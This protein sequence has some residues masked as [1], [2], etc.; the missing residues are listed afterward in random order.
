MR[1]VFLRSLLCLSAGVCGVLSAQDGPYPWRAAVAKSVITPKESVWMAG[2]A[3]RKGPSE[4]VLQDIYAKVL[5]LEDAQKGRMV[6]VTLDLVGIPKQLRVHVEKRAQKVN[7]LRPEQLLINASHTHSGPMIGV[8][9]PPKSGGKLAPTY[10][11]IPDD[12]KDFRVKQVLEYRAFLEKTIGDMI[13]KSLAELQACTLQWSHA[14]CGFS[15]NRRTPTKSGDWKNFPNPDGPVD[16]DVPVLQI[17]SR[18]DKQAPLAVLFGYACHATTLGL[19]EINGDWPGYA[20]TYFE[21]D[22]PGTVALFLNGASG[23]QNPYPR[24]TIPYVERH[25]RSMAT[26]IEAALETRQTAVRGPLASAIAWPEI[27]YQKPPSRAKLAEL[28]KSKNHWDASYGK[29]LLDTL[30]EK[31]SLP[32]SYPLPVQ[33]VRF[34]NSLTLA[35]IGGEV[36]VDYSLRLKKEL[37]AKTD[38]APVW[39]A[40]YSNDVPTYIPSRRV[41]EEGGYEGGGAM[42]Y[43]RGSVHPA[44]WETA[45]EEKLVGKVHELFDGLEK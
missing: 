17:R 39:F 10:T 29:F 6:F 16:Q 15:M 32:K 28:S 45:I 41:L 11:M 37:A 19:M 34:G 21:E 18:D 5:T 35:A 12:Q 3:A 31:G 20:Q 43:T 4:G 26:A 27:K 36:V 38:G 23:D 7:S 1:T 40:G 13:T 44:P 9:T 22:H 8:Y 2:Y 24:R 33:V 30:D 14:R 42:R 25:G